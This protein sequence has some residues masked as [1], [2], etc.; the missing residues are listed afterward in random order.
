MPGA[1]D[2]LTG[3]IDRGGPC[4]LLQKVEIELY[5]THNKFRKHVY[6]KYIYIYYPLDS[7]WEAEH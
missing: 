6:I 2:R 4:F 1:I 5:F 3:K 7:N